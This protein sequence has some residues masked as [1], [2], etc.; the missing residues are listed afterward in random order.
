MTEPNHRTAT[1]DA[2]LIST[3]RAAVQPRSFALWTSVAWQ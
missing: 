1:G 3:A 2:R